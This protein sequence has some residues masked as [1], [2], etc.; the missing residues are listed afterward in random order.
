MR[1]G[2][3]ALV[4]N[5]LALIC[6]GITIADAAESTRIVVLGDSLTAGYGLAEAD[7]FPAGLQAALT[8]NGHDVTVVNAGVSGDTTAG[9]RARVGWALAP[10][11]EGPA[12]ILIIELGANDGLRGLDPA[13]SE[14]NLNVI[15]TTAKS[16]GIR[17]MLTGMLAPP[18]LGR[19]YAAEFA[20]VFPRLAKKHG[21]ALY[22]FFLDGVAAV[23]ELNQKDGI[24]P[25]AEGV[26][27]IVERIL[28]HVERL[29]AQP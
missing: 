8:K 20:A 17:V 13:A 29:L 7:S 24:H 11:P 5:A 23:P 16:K 14:A 3:L 6:G 25:N 10:G 1:Y 21:V 9:G 28:P 12:D 18:N 15:I 2:A 27:V 4:V 22:P 26:K 19:E